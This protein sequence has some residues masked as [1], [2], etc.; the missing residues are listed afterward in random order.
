M[1]VGLCILYINHQHT[2]DN[3]TPLSNE[4][5]ISLL[6]KGSYA[7]IYLINGFSTLFNNYESLSNI[8]GYTIRIHEMVSVLHV[9]CDIITDT[10][11]ER[12]NSDLTSYG[13][14]LYYLL[15]GNKY[16]QYLQSDIEMH[17]TNNS[18]NH[19]QHG[20]THS[21]Y[22]DLHDSNYRHDNATVDKTDTWSNDLLSWMGKAVFGRHDRP[23]TQRSRVSDGYMYD[24]LEDIDGNRQCESIR[25][26]MKH[27]INKIDH[28]HIDSIIS[29]PDAVILSVRG[30]CIQVPH[31]HTCAS[32]TPLK[33]SHRI[34]ISNLTFEVRK[35]S[36]RNS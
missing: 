29:E 31:I 30:L 26:L 17:N 3:N 25:G 14:Y 13:S 28:D 6:T 24:R 27:D 15:Y 20:S 10:S 8:Y 22:D 4:E 23:F 16:N 11:I 18:H 33:Q 9:Q 32:T 36:N 2:Q 19:N 12:K 35:G 21:R 7:C 5:I 1:V 34:L